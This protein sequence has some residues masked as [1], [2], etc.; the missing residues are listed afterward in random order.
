MNKELEEA[1]KELQEKIRYLDRHINNYEK[2]NYKTNIYYELV[3]EKDALET[4]LQ[5][6]KKYTNKEKMLNSKYIDNIPEDKYIGITKQQY[7]EYLH[8]RDN[9]IPKEKVKKIF[10]TKIYNTKYLVKTDWTERQKEVDYRVARVLE[11]IEQELLE[12]NNERD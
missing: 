8:L 12:E 9:S 4:V 7:K 5:A 6:L 3:K 10:E 1:K 11:V 2:S